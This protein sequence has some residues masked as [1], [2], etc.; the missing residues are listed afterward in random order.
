MYLDPRNWFLLSQ[1]LGFYFPKE[2]VFIYFPK[3]FGPTGKVFAEFL[4]FGDL[5]DLELKTG[6]SR[7]G[8]SGFGSFP[9]WD[10]GKV[11]VGILKRVFWDFKNEFSGIRGIE[12]LVILGIELLGIG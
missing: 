6:P 3:K 2:L 12:F 1:R 4:G 8:F 5:R 11:F 9:S 7:A 10:F